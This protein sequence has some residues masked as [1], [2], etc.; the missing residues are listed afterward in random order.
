MCDRTPI[1]SS[2]PIGTLSNGEP[3]WNARVPGSKPSCHGKEKQWRVCRNGPSGG[4]VADPIP[5][6]CGLPSRRCRHRARSPSGTIRSRLD[7]STIADSSKSRSVT[8]SLPRRPTQ[9]GFSRRRARLHSICRQ[10]RSIQACSPLG[11]GGLAASGRA[12]RHIGTSPWRVSTWLLSD[13]RTRIRSQ[14]S[15]H[16]GTTYPSIQHVSNASSG[17]LAIAF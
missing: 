15:K 10:T 7:S 14:S 9:S 12:L 3:T 2:R 6:G 16:Y 17:R 8:C 11:E 1:E 4:G 13:G 5:A